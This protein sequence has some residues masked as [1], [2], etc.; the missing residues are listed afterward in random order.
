VEFYSEIITANL[1]VILSHEVAVLPSLCMKKHHHMLPWLMPEMF[2][3]IQMMHGSESDIQIWWTRGWKYRTRA[4]PECDRG[5]SYL[6]VARMTVL[7]LFCRMTN[8]QL[9]IWFLKLIFTA[10]CYASAVLAMGLC[11]SVCPSV[12][13]RS[14][15][16]KA[17]QR[18]TQTVPHDSPG[19][20][21]FWCQR[22]PR[23]ST[24]VTPYE[25]AECRWGGQN[26]RLSTND[27]LYL[28]NGKR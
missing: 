5:S 2:A 11:L 8:H 10:R 1:W 4:Q 26:G 13:S 14:S 28:E 9:K 3:I 22:S 6:N 21:V 23:N 27:R 20:L 16:K 12:T 15:T 18:I 7:H 25:G 19:T 24:G 17:K